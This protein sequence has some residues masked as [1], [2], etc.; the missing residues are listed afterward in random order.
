MI[1][2]GDGETISATVYFVESNPRAARH[3]A[4]MAHVPAAQVSFISRILV[5]KLNDMLEINRSP[6][7]WERENH[8]PAVA[9]MEQS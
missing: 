6:G 9:L 1:A 2:T 7:G 4:H 8:L 3:P 5:K